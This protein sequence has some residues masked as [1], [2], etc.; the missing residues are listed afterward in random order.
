MRLISWTLRSG[1]EHTLSVVVCLFRYKMNPHFGDETYG[2]VPKS[3]N[4]VQWGS[5]V[6]EGNIRGHIILVPVVQHPVFAC[7]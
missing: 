5:I 2:D 3:G 1:S 4:N 6:Q 7:Y